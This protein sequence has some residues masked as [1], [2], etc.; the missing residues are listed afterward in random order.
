MFS[1]GIWLT[2]SRMETTR[3][4]S[5][6]SADVVVEHEAAEGLEPSNNVVGSRDVGEVQTQ[7][8]TIIVVTSLDGG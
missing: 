4:R 5:P 2:G 8:G 7:L 3:L 6:D 1:P